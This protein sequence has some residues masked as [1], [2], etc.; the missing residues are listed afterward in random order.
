MSI[1][2]SDQHLV[3]QLRAR[4][5]YTESYIVVVLVR[6]PVADVVPECLGEY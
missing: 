5:R 4:T 1:L 3:A 2:E 6:S